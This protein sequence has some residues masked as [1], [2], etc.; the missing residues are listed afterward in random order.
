MLTT[1]QL[2][3]FYN[4]IG[5]VAAFAMVPVARR[6]G[7][8]LTHMV[9]LALCGGGLFF[10]AGLDDGAN[11]PPAL[12]AALA[13]PELGSH[14]A[15]MVPAL[16]LGLGW[17]SIMGNPYVILAGSIPPERTGVYMGIFNMMI[18]IPMLLN[19]LTFGWIYRHVLNSDPPHAIAFAGAMLA[20][21]AI[22]M[23]WVKAPERAAPVI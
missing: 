23:L 17:A 19:G 2:G 5:F 3:A 4:L 6:M 1:Q 14:L 22:T 9:S 13:M 16:G 10:M 21:A 11:A 20:C 18:V 8:R 15:L 12:L 7:A